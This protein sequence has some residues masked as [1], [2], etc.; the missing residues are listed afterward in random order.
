MEIPEYSRVISFNSI[1][2]VMFPI[3]MMQLK[4]TLP[5]GV[6]FSA[7]YFNESVKWERFI[8]PLELP[9]NKIQFSELISKKQK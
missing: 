3:L 7:D 6:K 5:E 1:P 4:T 8:D 9:E 2:A